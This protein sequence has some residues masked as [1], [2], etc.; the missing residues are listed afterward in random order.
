MIYGKKFALFLMG[1]AVTLLAA[2]GGEDAATKD[3]LE[4]DP[5]IESG[6]TAAAPAGLQIT[7]ASKSAISMLWT[8]STSTTITSYTIERSSAGAEAFSQLATGLTATTT[9]YTDAAVDQFT[10]YTYRVRAVDADG[11]SAPS[12]EDTAGPPP[13]GLQVAAP[14]PTDQGKVSEYGTNTSLALDENEDPLVAYVGEYTASATGDTCKL[15]FVRWDRAN[16]EWKT[17]VEVDAALGNIDGGFP[18]KQVS[19]ARDSS[20]GMLGIAYTVRDDQ[21]WLALSTD[22]GSTWFKERIEL[23]DDDI[24]GNDNTWV[25]LGPALALSGGKTHVA[26]FHRCMKAHLGG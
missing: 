23:N 26:Y 13:V 1:C 20:N 6:S 2:C 21:V 7:A 8:A 15:Y 16:Y 19:L 17:A 5:P 25:T 12:N 3:V 22:G 18:H 10:A 24:S 11:A 4:N 14:V 9:T